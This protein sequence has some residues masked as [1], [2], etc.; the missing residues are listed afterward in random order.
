MSVL[1]RGA[2]RDGTES[3][4]HS[5]DVEK[6]RRRRA[7]VSCYPGCGK[8]ARVHRNSPLSSSLILSPSPRA[9]LVPTSC[10]LLSYESLCS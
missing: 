1:R 3:V 7:Y 8:A 10:L 2:V 5:D 9:S 4:E 6:Q